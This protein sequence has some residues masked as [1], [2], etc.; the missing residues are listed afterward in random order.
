M[1]REFTNWRLGVIE[2]MAQKK[3]LIATD[4]ALAYLAKA[5]KYAHVTYMAHIVSNVS[6]L[7]KYT[8]KYGLLTGHYFLFYRSTYLGFFQ[9]VLCDLL[10]YKG[11][12]VK[13]ADFEKF[14]NFMLDNFYM[15]GDDEGKALLK[16]DAK[17]LQL[18]ID[19]KSQAYNTAT[20]EIEQDA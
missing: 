18:E 10:L 9:S 12:F 1:L 16:R 2:H 8:Y 20:S 19:M 7:N 14:A 11:H 15:V 5:G 17:A 4:Q 3:G 6:D 13:Q